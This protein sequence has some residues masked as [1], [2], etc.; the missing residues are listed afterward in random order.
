MTLGPSIKN[1]VSLTLKF[2]LFCL[3]QGLL[4]Q[5]AL[6]ITPACHLFLEIKFYWDTALPTCSGI[7]FPICGCFPVTTE[8]MAHSARHICCPALQKKLADLC[9]KHYV[10]HDILETWP[11]T[12]LPS[13]PGEPHGPGG[14]V[15]PIQLPR[16]SCIKPLLHCSLGL[17]RKDPRVF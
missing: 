6:G 16:A 7:C 2:Q 12:G 9:S 15:L 8:T 5:T 13:L 1:Q 11:V 4:N 17:Q 10:A 14:S 3:N